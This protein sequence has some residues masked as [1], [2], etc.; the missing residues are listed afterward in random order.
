M[1]SLHALL[2][3]SLIA[4]FSS[5]ICFTPTKVGQDKTGDK[6][7]TNTVPSQTSPQSSEESPQAPV[8]KHRLSSK[9]DTVGLEAID[10]DLAQCLQRPDTL[11]EKS[12][13]ERNYIYRTTMEGKMIVKLGSTERA[14]RKR[15]KKEDENKCSWILNSLRDNVEDMF[16]FW[17]SRPP[18]RCG[19]TQQETSL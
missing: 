13:Y 7:G 14:T 15:I 8:K 19:P 11:P 18:Y 1:R 6:T 12:V 3:S 9:F 4:S 17:T 2:T 16:H 5:H 10:E